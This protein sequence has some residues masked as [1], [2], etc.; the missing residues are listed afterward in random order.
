MPVALAD[1]LDIR[2]G[3][4]VTEIDYGGPG[5]TVKATSS[6]QPNQPQTF[7]GTVTLSLFIHCNN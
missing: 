3:T 1:G 5:V 6:R 7:K 2:L 4:A